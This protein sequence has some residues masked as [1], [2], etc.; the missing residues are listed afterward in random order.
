[1]K[2][3]SLILFLLFVVTS[4]TTTPRPK[5]RTAGD[6]KGQLSSD[7]SLQTKNFSNFEEIHL[8]LEAIAETDLKELR[9][10][11]EMKDWLKRNANRRTQKKSTIIIGYLQSKMRGFYT[12]RKFTFFVYNKN[13]DEPLGFYYDNGKT[14]RY[15][16]NFDGKW[17]EQYLGTFVPMLSISEILRIKGD[18]EIKPLRSFRKRFSK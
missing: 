11:S 5:K 2:Q 3:L 17:D 7:E 18:M 16:R 8:A 4:C 9:V 1:M 14:Y 15:V 10:T 6:P 12:D 13:F